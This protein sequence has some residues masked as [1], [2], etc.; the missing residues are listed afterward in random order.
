MR[1]FAIKFFSNLPVNKKHFIREFKL[2]GVKSSFL[3]DYDDL[4][5]I[6]TKLTKNSYKTS[7]VIDRAKSILEEDS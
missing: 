3:F 2:I 7:L 6:S 4:I 5:L 1:V